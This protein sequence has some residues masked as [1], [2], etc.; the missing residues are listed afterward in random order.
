MSTGEYIIRQEGD[1]CAYETTFWSRT[2]STKKFDLEDF[3]KFVGQQTARSYQ[4]GYLVLTNYNL[5]FVTSGLATGILAQELGERTP[6]G[7]GRKMFAWKKLSLKEVYRYYE[8]NPGGVKIPLTSIAR[9]KKRSPILGRP[10]AIVI[11]RGESEYRGITFSFKGF[12]GSRDWPEAILRQAK[13]ARG[14]AVPPPPPA[15][16]QTPLCPH[17]GKPLT[18]IPQYKRWYCYNC[19]KYA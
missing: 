14:Q 12:F 1:V 7:I 10:A 11:W 4:I 16:P 18:W 6:F 15:Q 8:K 13:I 3:T 2:I 19:Q 17:C 9:V 5:F